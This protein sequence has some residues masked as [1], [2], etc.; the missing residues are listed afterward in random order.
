MAKTTNL[1]SHDFDDWAAEA[2]IVGVIEDYDHD[3]DGCDFETVYDGRVKPCDSDDEYLIKYRGPGD[4]SSSIAFACKS[5]AASFMEA[6][7]G[8]QGEHSL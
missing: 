3:P 2:E 1:S 5:C 4:L 8:Q 7:E 6:V